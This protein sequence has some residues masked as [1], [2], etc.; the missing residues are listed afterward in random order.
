MYSCGTYWMDRMYHSNLTE[1]ATLVSKGEC[2]TLS[3][4]PVLIL[5]VGKTKGTFIYDA[6]AG[7]TGQRGTQFACNMFCYS[8]YCIYLKQT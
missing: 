8:F 6:L 2:L 5:I 7:I 1:T 4:P 3:T